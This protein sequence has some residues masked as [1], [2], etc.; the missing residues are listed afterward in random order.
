MPTPKIRIGMRKYQDYFRE[1]QELME[2]LATHSQTPEVLFISCADAR[3][4]PALM[5][6][7]EPG[8]LFVVRNLANVVPPLG[9][10]QMGMGAI[11]EYALLHLRIAH[12]VICGHTDCGGIKALGTHVDWRRESHIAR[13]LEYART[14]QSKIEVSGLPEE[15][16]HLA[17]VRENVLLQLEHL[18]TYSPVSEGERSGTL[19]LH[20]WVYHVETGMVEAYDP[21][22][23][24]WLPYDLQQEPEPSN[25]V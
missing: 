13:W 14:I 19:T 10:G 16:R 9:A 5:V 11:I 7:A 6:G 12:I 21:L 8:D 25:S 20:G 17:L 18:R 3:V 1:N 23:K 4:V 24:A 22:T 15:E 2:R